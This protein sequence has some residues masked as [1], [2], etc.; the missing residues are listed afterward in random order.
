MVTEEQLQ[1]LESVV[2]AVRRYGN[3]HTGTMCAR[4]LA[5][6]CSTTSPTWSPPSARY[7]RD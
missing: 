1:R 4:Q 7:R 5:P 2:A 6:S 3:N